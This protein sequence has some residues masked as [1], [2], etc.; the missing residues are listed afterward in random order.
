M[1]IILNELS[2]KE[3]YLPATA[4]DANK[5]LDQWL[6]IVE[7]IVRQHRT[8]PQFRPPFKT[9]TS[10]SNL[11]VAADGHVFSQWVK[12]MP[13]E[14]RALALSATKAGWFIRESYPEYR[15][16]SPVPSHCQDS[17]CV[18]FAYAIENNCLTWS[19]DANQE[20]TDY[21]YD[22]VRLVIDE[23]GGDID[24]ETISA[25][26]IPASGLNAT[27]QLYFDNLLS[28]AEKQ[29]AQSC[30][31]GQD[32]LDNW[33]NWF[34][35]LR[36]TSVAEYGLRTL[37]GAM[38]QPIA[39]RLITLQRYFKHWD[40]APADYS[41]LGFHTTPES[42][43]RQ[44]ELISLTLTLPDRTDV[45]M[46]WHMRYPLGQRGAGRLFFVPDSTTLTCYIGYIGSKDGVT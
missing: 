6:E 13:I 22:L 7:S 40:G 29:I 4:E 3:H 37:P 15:F 46:D 8:T 25:W 19:L 26:H 43:R 34:S 44:K 23:D 32:L 20:W 11:V 12:N 42:P 30:R 38:V 33:E 16:G 14:R 5:L 21:Q 18:G 24:E 28:A 17:E 27:H 41:F 1:D 10:F 2:V 31:S 39:E 36:L 35:V 9:A 45:L